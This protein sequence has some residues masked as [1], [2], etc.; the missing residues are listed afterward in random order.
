MWQTYSAKNLTKKR[1][2]KDIAL[3]NNV[4]PNTVERVMD[5]YYNIQRLY[6]NYLPKVL[7]FD[8]F[9]S[10]KSADGAM[11]FHLCNGLTGQ[12][13]D[14]VEDRRLSSLLKYF[15]Y[16]SH[17]ARSKVKFIVIDMY[18][19][20]ISLIKT[21]FPNAQIIIDKFHLVQL[22]SRS[23]NKAK[24]DGHKKAIFSTYIRKNRLFF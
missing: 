22:V 13:I 11:S 23:L 3:D 7:S 1:S 16:Y 5:S 12:T 6:K 4:S 21:M 2:E 20:Y 9:K 8:E 18:S 17:K 24:Y 19:P 15:S 14:I 10:V